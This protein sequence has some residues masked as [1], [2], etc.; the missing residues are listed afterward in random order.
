MYNIT[1]LYISHNNDCKNGFWLEVTV[2]YTSFSYLVGERLQDIYI[3]A[4]LQSLWIIYILSHYLI[5]IF[6]VWQVREQKIL[7]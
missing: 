5:F 2:F 4:T 7:N 6:F 1:V 3:A